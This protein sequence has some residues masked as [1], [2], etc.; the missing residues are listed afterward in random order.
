MPVIRI[1]ALVAL[2]L[3]VPVF[4]WLVFYPRGQWIA[5]EY[6]LSIFVT[7][8]AAVNS[9]AIARLAKRARRNWLGSLGQALVVIGALCALMLA[10]APA[11]FDLVAPA[12]D[13]GSELV[14]LPRIG[15]SYL[16]VFGLL[17]TSIAA[18]AA[19]WGLWLLSR[20]LGRRAG[21]LAA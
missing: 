18:F 12:N 10:S 6:G 17:E 8:F 20:L 11:W 7:V 13:P 1:A 16:V 15:F 21:R 5:G 2:G 14:S 9:M 4:L 19:G 3:A